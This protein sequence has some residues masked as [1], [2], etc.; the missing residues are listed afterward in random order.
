MASSASKMTP[1]EIKDLVR[2][3]EA[4]GQMD[5]VLIEAQMGGSR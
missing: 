3:L 2:S 5:A 1:E 4:M